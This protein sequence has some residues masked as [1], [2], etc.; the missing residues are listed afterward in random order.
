M[1]QRKATKRINGALEKNS[2]KQL[3]G[4]ISCPWQTFGDL[5]YYTAL[6]QDAK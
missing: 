6:S 4:I 3:Q 2:T 5:F 1:M